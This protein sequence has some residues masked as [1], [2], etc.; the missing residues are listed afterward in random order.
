MKLFR[1]RWADVKPVYTNVETIN[2]KLKFVKNNNYTFSKGSLG[3]SLLKNRFSYQYIEDK[4]KIEI[5]IIHSY[6][7]LERYIVKKIFEDD[8]LK[9]SSGISG[10]EA[11]KYVEELFQ[12]TKNTDITLYKA[13][14][15]SKYREE[16]KLVKNCVP[17]QIA[18][19]NPYIC[20]KKVSNSFKA[21]KS[22]AFPSQMTKELPTFHDCKKMK[23]IIEPTEEYPFAFYVVS[24]H[25]NIYNELDTHNMK[26]RFYSF[27][28]DC[29]NDSV[30]PEEEIT[31]LCKKSEYSL[32]EE[33]EY[34]YSQRKIDENQKMYM[35]ACIGFFHRN[36]DPRLSLLAAVVIARNNDDMLKKAIQLYDEGNGILY[37]ATDC[38]IWKG[39]ESSVAT[40]EKYLGSFTYEGK[41]GQ[42]FGRMVGSY[43]YLENEL[44]TKCSYLK[45]TE[46]KYKIPFGYLP[47]PKHDSL[48]VKVGDGE[49][50]I[51]IINLLG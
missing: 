39:K 2:E 5:R 25:I 6:K 15:G 48:F 47:E 3:G 41:N 9:K 32:K 29:Y 7:Q 37:I 26:N 38:I 8:E 14:S 42:F 24:G 11:Y 45:N 46:D 36:G 18:Y 13:F 35:N 17:K 30:K 28:N 20:G 33:F 16:Y 12:N 1:F 23:G 22:S 51:Q 34:M 44:V 49:T 43:Q 50:G 21:D 19:I 40:D 4:R 27:Y 10:M 31:I